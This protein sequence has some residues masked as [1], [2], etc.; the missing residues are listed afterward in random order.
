MD[1]SNASLLD[2]ATAAAVCIYSFRCKSA[3][4]RMEHN[5]RLLPLAWIDAIS[6][7]G[8]VKIV[9]HGHH[10]CKY[11]AIIPLRSNPGGGRGSVSVSKLAL[12]VLCRLPRAITLVG[13]AVERHVLRINARLNSR[14]RLKL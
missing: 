3:A 2:E 9:V 4:P 5:K 12:Q 10:C 14:K 8:V 6:A 1:M 11:K 13:G 7:E